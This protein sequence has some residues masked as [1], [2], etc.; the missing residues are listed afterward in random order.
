LRDLTAAIRAGLLDRAKKDDL[1]AIEA[2][3]GALLDRRAPS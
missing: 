3:I 2:A 1:P